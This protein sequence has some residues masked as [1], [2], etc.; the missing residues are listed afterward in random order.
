M[1]GFRKRKVQDLQK[2]FPDC[3]GRMINMLDLNFG[4]AGAKLLADK[5]HGDGILQT[6][7]LDAVSFSYFSCKVLRL[8]L[9]SCENY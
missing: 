2:P 1:S 5:A 4:M 6:H 9:W 3:M 7:L 8:N